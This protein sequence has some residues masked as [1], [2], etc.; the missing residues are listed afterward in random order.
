MKKPSIKTL[1]KKLDKEWSR[2]IRSEGECEVCGKKDNKCQ[3][4][5][6]H[7]IGRRNLA[8]RWDLDNGW[9]LCALNHQL[10]LLSAHQNPE[11]FRREAIRIRG[12]DYPAMMLKQASKV[13]K[14]TYDELVEL[15]NKL[16]AT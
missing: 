15:L 16:K 2:I 6:H 4:H 11:W 12:V 3:L 1:K 9:C 5:P 13:K 14:W 7:F 10:G 8:T